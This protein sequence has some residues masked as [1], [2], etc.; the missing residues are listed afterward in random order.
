MVRRDFLDS[1]HSAVVRSEYTGSGRQVV[2]RLIEKSMSRD[3]FVGHIDDEE[4]IEIKG[5][6]AMYCIAL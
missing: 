1:A 3:P 6:V 2:T 4:A 5:G